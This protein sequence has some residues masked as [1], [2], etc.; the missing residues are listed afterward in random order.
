M[1]YLYGMNFLSG[2]GGMFEYKYSVND[3]YQSK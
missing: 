2:C 1:R 3:Q